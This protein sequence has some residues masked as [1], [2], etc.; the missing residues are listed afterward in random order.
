MELPVP[1]RVPVKIERVWEACI[2][3]ESRVM[4]GL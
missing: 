3:N 1:G 2:T 4:D